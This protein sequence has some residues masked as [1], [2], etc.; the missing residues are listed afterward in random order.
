M[1]KQQ[2]RWRRFSIAS[3]VIALLWAGAM[4]AAGENETSERLW[5]CQRG[6]ENPLRTDSDGLFD[7]PFFSA[8]QRDCEGQLAATG[9]S[10]VYVFQVDFKIVDGASKSKKIAIIKQPLTYYAAA[11]AGIL[12]G[13]LLALMFGIGIMTPRPWRRA[14]QS[15]AVVV[16]VGAAWFATFGFI[17]LSEKEAFKGHI[18]A[19]VIGCTLA[20]A[21]Y[22][23]GERDADND[24]LSAASL[25]KA[26]IDGN[27]WHDLRVS[28]A[29]I[30]NDHGH[31]GGVTKITKIENPD[32][33]YGLIWGA[34][35]LIGAWFAENF[36][37]GDEWLYVAWAGMAYSAYRLGVGMWSIYG[38]EAKRP[39]PLGPA[40]STIKSGFLRLLIGIALTPVMA[41]QNIFDYDL[42][43]LTL[44]FAGLGAIYILLGSLRAL[45]YIMGSPEKKA[46]YHDQI[47]AHTMIHTL[48]AVVLMDRNIASIE[49]D[50]LVHKLDDDLR[51][52]ANADLLRKTAI[53]IA[54]EI[55][56]EKFSLTAYLRR[57]SGDL[58]PQMKRH[59][60]KCAH[61]LV[62]RNDRQ[63]SANKGCLHHIA[64]GL[65]LP[66]H[67]HDEIRAELLNRL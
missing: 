39:S 51:D 9:K 3:I 35:A 65:G 29:R 6:L 1:E 67:Y 54:G 23:L 13:P 34:A 58:E 25:K 44:L 31:G 38:P 27:E 55:V 20:A 28:L 33:N 56:E 11:F 45:I 61:K 59:I 53:D 66:P 47:Y 2:W 10:G 26:A 42:E 12:A 63:A 41:D 8:Y 60:L 32:I 62:N 4:Y 57:Q 21:Y 46:E 49:L 14:A 64:S 24:Q 40:G 50:E 36:I 7:K 19:A 18:I 30:N 15:I 22:F 48:L 16:S 52:I 43:F 5:L 17:G 37:A